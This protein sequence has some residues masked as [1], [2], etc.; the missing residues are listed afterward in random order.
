[1]K[2]KI[3]SGEGVDETWQQL[4]ND[5]E[6]N[7]QVLEYTALLQTGGK[8][9]TFSMD[10]DPGGGFESGFSTTLFSAP[11]HRAH[12]LHLSLHKEHFLDEAGK[13]LGMQDVEIGFADF[14]KKVIIKTNDEALARKAFSSSFVQSVLGTIDDYQL[15]IR[16]HDVDEKELSFLELSIEDRVPELDELKKIFE[17]FCQ[18]LSAIEEN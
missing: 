14:D 2:E 5:L 1:M 11:L 16:R 9:V 17:A 4:Q 18:I 15:K 8:S 3:F 6:S 10:I 12:H 13:L 7:A